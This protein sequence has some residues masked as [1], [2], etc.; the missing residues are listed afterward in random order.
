[1][2]IALVALGMLLISA[3]LFIVMVAGSQHNWLLA[4]GGFFVLIAGLYVK[5]KAS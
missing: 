4:I 5:D 3:A 2:K 1:M